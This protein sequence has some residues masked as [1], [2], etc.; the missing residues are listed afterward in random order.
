MSTVIAQILDQLDVVLKANVPAGTQVYR[1][2]VDAESRAEEP[3]VNVLVRDDES[4]PES[5]D[6]DLH[7][8]TIEI[9][10]DV[11]DDVPT[12]VAETIHGAV[13]GPIVTDAVLRGLAPGIRI[14]ASSYEREEAD[15]TSLIKVCSYRFKY[16]INQST[17]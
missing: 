12:P 16:L 9:R 4:E 2:R 8:A 6:F 13:H 5:D 10:I 11:R 17:L 14:V 7:Q 1:D 15:L 3:C